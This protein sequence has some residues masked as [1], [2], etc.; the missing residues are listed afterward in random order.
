MRMDRFKQVEPAIEKA[1]SD[2]GMKCYGLTVTAFQ[3]KYL[4]SRSSG[5]LRLE[6]PLTKCVESLIRDFGPDT[7]LTFCMYPGDD[8]LS[9]YLLVRETE[10]GVWP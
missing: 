3:A 4:V 2:N 8:L 1:L 9:P 10:T 5:K 7:G 6:E